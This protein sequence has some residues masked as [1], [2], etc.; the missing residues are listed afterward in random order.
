MLSLQGSLVYFPKDFLLPL[1]H[2][3]FVRYDDTN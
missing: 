2:K 3:D 1:A